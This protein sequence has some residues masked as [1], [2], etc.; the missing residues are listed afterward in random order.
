MG[1]RHNRVAVSV[2]QE[3]IQREGLTNRSKPGGRGSF[4]SQSKTWR[5]G[6]LHCN[7]KKIS[8]LLSLPYFRRNVFAYCF[9]Y[10]G[11]SA[12]G[13]NLKDSPMKINFE[14]LPY[15]IQVWLMRDH[16]ERILR[17]DPMFREM[18]FAFAEQHQSAGVR[19]QMRPL[20]SRPE[21]Q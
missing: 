14:D 15:R 19:V 12:T 8:P 2:M 4:T 7:I 6:R 13:Q 5:G 20:L 9:L 17:E 3:R 11:N 18:E 16:A 10:R 21:K 1:I